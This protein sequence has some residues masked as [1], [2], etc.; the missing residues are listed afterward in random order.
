MNVRR[1]GTDLL[2][3]AHDGPETVSKIS[4]CFSL[5]KLSHDRVGQVNICHLVASLIHDLWLAADATDIN[6]A[7]SVLLVP[8]PPVQREPTMELSCA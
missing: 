4:P 2:P 1:K 3:M 5:R 6:H 8:T 7:T